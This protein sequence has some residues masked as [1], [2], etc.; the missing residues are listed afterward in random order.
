MTVSQATAECEAYE[1]SMDI[2]NYPPL[3]SNFT[4]NVTDSY[5][6]ND[7]HGFLETFGTH[8]VFQLNMGGRFTFEAS[9]KP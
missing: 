1:L 8:F 9:L 7:W 5:K 2:F 4:K 6:A 3:M